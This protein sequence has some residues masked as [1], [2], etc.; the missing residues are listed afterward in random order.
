MNGYEFVEKV[1]GQTNYDV[2]PLIEISEGIETE[3]LEFK[4][5]TAPSDGNFKNNENKPARKKYPHTN[6]IHLCLPA[7]WWPC[8]NVFFQRAAVAIYKRASRIIHTE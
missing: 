6:T 7:S 3:W 1:L 5:A 2:E 8:I 4:A